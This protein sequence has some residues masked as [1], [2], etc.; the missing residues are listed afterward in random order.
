MGNNNILVTITTVTLNSE[1]TLKRTIESVLN[2]TYPNIEYIIKDGGSNDNTIKIAKSFSKKFEEKGYRFIIV[3][4]K[5]HGMYDALNQ[6]NELGEGIIVGNVNSDDY[7]EQDAVETMVDMFKKTNFDMAY[8]NLRVIG[9]HRQKI[10]KARL[11]KFV[12]S[13]YWN[14][15]TTFIKREVLIFEKYKCKSM[16]DDFDL[17]LRLRKK[18]VVVIVDKVL[19]NF[20][21]GGMS[22]KKSLR[23]TWKRIK[24]KNSIYRENGFSGIRYRVDT[25]LIEFA[26]LFF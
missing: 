4:K 2:Q 11:C 22:N 21:F 8:A 23:E 5:D 18:Y 10:K 25:F 3:S 20:V 9:K 6:A 24:L 7:F 16:Y 17:M 1:K 15:P 14:H 19:S 13:R 12:S 26:K